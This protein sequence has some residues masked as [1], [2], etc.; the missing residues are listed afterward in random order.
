MAV[1]AVLELLRCIHLLN[2]S[3]LVRPQSSSVRRF[4]EHRPDVAHL[5]M[6]DH[7]LSPSI[8]HALKKFNVPVIQ[9]VHQYKLVCPNY[10]FYNPA[11]G[12][13]CEK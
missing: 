10:R 2:D 1:A 4:A 12:E 13:I 11:S 9:T 5:H 6:I 8:L 3:S 7:Q